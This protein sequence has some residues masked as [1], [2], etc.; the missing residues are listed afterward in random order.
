MLL[1]THR[2]RSGTAIVPEERPFVSPAQ[3][4]IIPRLMPMGRFTNRPYEAMG[5]S[6]EVVAMSA[7]VI[8]LVTFRLKPGIDEATFRAAVETSMP[9]LL[10]QAGFLGREVGV[11]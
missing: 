1:S 9:F 4:A 7:Q 11:S 6:I 5:L 10:R 2:R 3:L 8:E